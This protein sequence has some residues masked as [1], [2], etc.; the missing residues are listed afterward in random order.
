MSEPPRNWDKELSDIDR[1]IEQQGAGAPDPHG[2]TVAPRPT[3]PPAAPPAGR[4]SV[5]VT[6]LWVLLALALAVA[7]PLWPY[8][9]TCGMQIVFFLGAAV[10]TAIVGGLAAVSSWT[11]RRALAHVVSLLVIAWAGAVAASEILPRTGYAREAKTWTCVAEPATSA[12]AT[13]APST[14]AP[15]PADPTPASPAPAEGGPAAP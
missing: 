13:P 14:A 10:I 8:Q 15:P 3:P 4:G 7:L 5:A 6:W 1:V 11:T 12:P 9:R 2:G